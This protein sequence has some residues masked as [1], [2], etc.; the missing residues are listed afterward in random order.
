V[1]LYSNVMHVIEGCRNTWQASRLVIGQRVALPRIPTKEPILYAV[2]MQGCASPYC[3][4]CI[5]GQMTEAL[6]SLRGEWQKDHSKY[7][8]VCFRPIWHAWSPGDAWTCPG[9]KPPVSYSQLIRDPLET[10]QPNIN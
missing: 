1:L 3:S 10:D 2:I 8:I 4:N 6:T 7:Y 5:V 9:R